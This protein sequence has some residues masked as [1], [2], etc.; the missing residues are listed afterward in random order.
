MAVE[1]A[2]TPTV[3][4]ALLPPLVNTVVVV[5]EGGNG[6]GAWVFDGTL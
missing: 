3:V 6:K 1:T 5:L 2:G 4:V